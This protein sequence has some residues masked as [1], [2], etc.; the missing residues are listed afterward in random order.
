MGASVG[1][2]EGC[3]AIERR[4]HALAIFAAVSGGSAD[5]RVSHG[6]GDSFDVFSGIEEMRA[7]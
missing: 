2:G 4:E 1:K 7:E 5:V 6:F 3:D